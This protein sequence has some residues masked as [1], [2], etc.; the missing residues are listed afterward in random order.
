[1][2]SDREM[3]LLNQ[4]RVRASELGCALWRNNSGACRDATGRFVRF[5]L[6]ND[7]AAL[8]RL[9]KSSDLVGVGPG[10]RFLAVEIKPPGWRYTGTGREL[11]QEAFLNHVRAL[12]GL[13][14]FAT[15]IEDVEKI[16]R[17]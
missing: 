15:A 14:G 13:A 6:G 4:A 3:P 1:M 8:C 10:G 17:G 16:I 12:R 11:A 9:W 5:G 7:S 2:T